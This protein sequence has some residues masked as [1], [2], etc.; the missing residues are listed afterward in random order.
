MQIPRRLNAV[1]KPKGRPDTVAGGM[2][3]RPTFGF[4]AEPSSGRPVGARLG[5]ESTG[6]VGFAVDVV[7]ATAG[8]GA[9]LATARASWHT[10]GG[11][12][13]HSGFDE[14]TPPQRSAALIRNEN[15]VGHSFPVTSRSSFPK[16]GE[17]AMPFGVAWPRHG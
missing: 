9:G 3:K 15:M 13:I 2:L 10:D 14:R 12:C 1:L 17:Y 16:A 5:S 8:R 6:V 11:A 4:G 7:A